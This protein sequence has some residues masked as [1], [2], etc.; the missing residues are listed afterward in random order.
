MSE[1]LTPNR[2]ELLK[3][4]IAPFFAR[5]ARGA[6]RPPN[7]NFFLT[8]DHGAWATR[9]YGC[10]DMHTPNLDRLASEGAR[11]TRAYACTPVC[12]PSRMTYLTGKLPSHH[13]VQDWILNDE[14]VGPKSRPFLQGQTTFSEILANH[15]YTVGLSGKWHMG[16]DERAQAGFSYWATVPGGGG[17]YKNAVFVKN[18]QPLATEGY[19]TNHVGNHAMEFIEQNRDRPFCLYCPFFAPHVP[20]DYQPEEFRRFYNNASFP[21]FP[22]EP[23]HP[24]HTRTIMGRPFPM[25]DDFNNRE[26]KLSYSALVAGMDHNV[27][28]ILQRL[29]ELEIRDNTVIIFSADQGHNCGHHGIWGKGNSTVPFN[30]YDTSLHVPL[31]WNHRG[32]IKPHQVPTPMVSSYDF[33][34]TL[35]EYLGGYVGIQAPPDPHRVGRSYAGFLHGRNP[36][37]HNELYFEYQ[38]VRGIRTENLKYVERTAEWPSELFDLEADPGERQNVID[39]PR[40]ARQLKAL[41]GRLTA[42]FDEAGAPK[43]DQWRSTTT[44]TLCTYS[45]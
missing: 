42:F 31:I 14:S 24:W 41:R 26:S 11:F 43:I 38:Y 21:C 5:T 36:S 37:W 22:N 3:G 33:F 6:T 29:E 39:D 18:G 12:S 20:Y 44:E 15:G 8:D 40:H 2:R 35:L 23:I 10:L 17:T 13:G 27:G 9:C 25:L 16:G 19:K 28:R 32:H 7:V 30:M 1:H 45:R 4:T 34:P